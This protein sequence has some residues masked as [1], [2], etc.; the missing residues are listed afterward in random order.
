LR[1]R[2]GDRPDVGS[3]DEEGRAAHEP[4]EAGSHRLPIAQTPIIGRERD[5]AVAAELLHRADVRLLTLTGAGGTGKTRLALQLAADSARAFDQRVAFV[6]LSP[7][8]DPTLLLPLIGHATGIR[9]SAARSIP[10]ALRRVIGDQLFLLVLDNFEQLL[11]ASDQVAELLGQVSGL[12]IL[13]TSREA[14]RLRWEHELPL[15]PLP[16]PSESLG[17]GK[18]SIATIPS[19]A[20][21]VQRARAVQPS[22]ALTET[23]ALAV[24]EI[25]RLLD[26]LPLAI[27][28]AAPYLKLL[29]PSALLER[30]ERRLDLLERGPRDAPDRHRTLRG[31][32]RWSYDLLSPRQQALFR[33]LAVFSGG[34]SLG[35]T[36]QVC[37]ALGPEMPKE[38][39]GP[40]LEDLA[41]LVDKSLIQ[42]AED[43]AGE[44]RF[45]M[46]ETVH[47]FAAELLRASD[48]VTDLRERHARH[49]L[50]RVAEIE[51]RL[52]GAE[53]L[54]WVAH[55]A[56]EQDNVR[57]ALRWF[58]DRAAWAAA[59]EL[60][61]RQWW[62]WWMHG[63]MPEARRWSEAILAADSVL[64]VEARADA[65]LVAASAAIE[66]GEFAL[67]RDLLGPA[68]DA[69]RSVGD[70]WGVGHC[71]ILKGF[72]SPAVD[73]IA[74]GNH[75]FREAQTWLRAADDQRGVGLSLT[76]LSA[77]A[78]LSGDFGA[79]Q[80]FAEQRLELARAMGD[81]QGTSQAL[82]DL[83]LA[84]LL[85]RDDARAAAALGE[86]LPLCLEVGQQELAADCLMGLASVATRQDE[87]VRAAQLFGAA[88][89]L[90]E[91]VG[92]ALWPVRLNLY[93]A[94]LTSLRRVLGHT[95][96]AAAWAEG[97]RWSV[98]EAADQALGPATT[99]G[100]GPRGAGA[101][102]A[103]SSYRPVDP[104][105]RPL[106]R[107]EREVAALIGRG[108][109]SAEIAAQLVLSER[110]VDTHA[111]HIR[112][113]LG[114]RSRAEIAAWAALHGLVMP[115]PSE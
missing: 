108:L 33:D 73:T 24:A 40:V 78:V 54:R 62:F 99:S 28:L 64:P 53:Q 103:G 38:D 8:R 3:A 63:Q 12:K 79:A 37:R 81:P 110:T 77:L 115:P 100:E 47:E 98:R 20:L 105:L 57:A 39:S 75:C 23:N 41:S 32:I 101:R 102:P 111:D 93:D 109:T 65:C 13:V 36:E 68:L 113:K 91:A 48:A 25:C 55:L 74:A 85:R 7:V 96:F 1:H 87:P 114:L 42:V 16:T 17:P 27:E 95:E 58:L 72:I 51:P 35:A 84:L 19:V 52:W 43:P 11:A 4:G 49:V 22:F 80:R 61:R 2:G 82:D 71:L 10:E 88:E 50:A 21:F 59:A 45:R 112:Q 26:G 94:E 66:R 83:G 92:V 18:E 60:V 86:A 15:L 97:K 34:A 56:A 46:L 31:A 69:Y 70:R 107:R 104:A 30:L 89:A 90:R 5:L 29:S 44:P 76:G 106:S 9:E 6:D 14:L 67:S